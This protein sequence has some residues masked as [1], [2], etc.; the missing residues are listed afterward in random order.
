MFFF[1]F[2][3]IIHEHNRSGPVT[4]GADL[5]WCPDPERTNY[6]RS[7]IELS[8]DMKEGYKR[9]IGGVPKSASSRK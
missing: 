9:I 7:L 4:L 6:T 5:R 3:P 1:H 8:I 2:H